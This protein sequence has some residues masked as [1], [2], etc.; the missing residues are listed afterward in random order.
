MILEKIVALYIASSLT[1]M[2]V[3]GINILKENMTTLGPGTTQTR[4]KAKEHYA[5][6]V[7]YEET[8]DVDFPWNA[9]GKPD[10]KTDPGAAYAI[11]HQGGVLTLKMSKPF[12]F[13]TFYDSGR[14]VAKK[15]CN[16]TVAAKV[17][18][19]DTYAW[20][21]ILPGVVPGGISIHQSS[22]VWVD[23]IK[24]INIGDKPAYIDAVIGYGYDNE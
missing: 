12:A 2:P 16:C 1:A 13:Y 24:I 20:R 3:S 5:Q 22:G 10:A 15:G 4:I 6:K 19:E 23:T 9:L 8:K 17:P 18:I 14:I 21:E 7:I 11:I